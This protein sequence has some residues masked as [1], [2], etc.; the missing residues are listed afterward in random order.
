MPNTLAPK[1]Y[2][3]IGPNNGQFAGAITELPFDSAAATTY[4]GDLVT[5]G[6]NGLLGRATATGLIR[7]VAVGFRW[8]DASGKP[9]VS[10]YWPSGTTVQAGSLFCQCIDDPNV[11]FEVQ[12][13]NT[14]SAIDQ[15]W[16][17]STANSFDTGGNAATGQ[18]GLVLDVS[19]A[20]SAALRQWRIQGFVDRPD[21]DKASAYAKVKVVAINHELRVQTGI[22]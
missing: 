8:I 17:G 6:S 12:I 1:G 2:R 7:G 21:N 9:V 22:A 11:V 5:T 18:S 20:Q 14:T 13:G 3:P 16:V 10:P 4:Q 15:T 19:G